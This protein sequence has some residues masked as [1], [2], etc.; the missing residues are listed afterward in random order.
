MAR[1]LTSEE[2][3]KEQRERIFA[4]F[5]GRM[6]GFTG[7]RTPRTSRAWTPS[8]LAVSITATMGYGSGLVIP[9]TGIP[10]NNTLGEP[11]L[12]PKGFTRSSPGSA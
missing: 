11:E 2:Y 6:G 9:G 10:M 4:P 12:N 7:A 1:R 8:G 5:G 3:A